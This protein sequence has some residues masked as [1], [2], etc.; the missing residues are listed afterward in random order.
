M[1]ESFLHLSLEAYP[2]RS[3]RVLRIPAAVEVSPEPAGV[4]PRDIIILDVERERL[5]N[6]K[7]AA[8][9]IELSPSCVIVVELDAVLICPEAPSF[10][11]F[12]LRECLPH[13]YILKSI[14]PSF[15]DDCFWLHFSNP[16]HVFFIIITILILFYMP[17]ISHAFK[18]KC[19]RF[20]DN[21][22]ASMHLALL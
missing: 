15:N 6:E 5:F 11:N 3:K 10:W 22:Q 18:T 9:K 19:L 4:E 8:P 16:S 12:D 13:L 20:M 7:P 1:S 21:I 17:A 14:F 2:E